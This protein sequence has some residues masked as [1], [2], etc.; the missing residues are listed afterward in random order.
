[1]NLTKKTPWNRREALARQIEMTCTSPTWRK[2][3]RD[4]ESRGRRLSLLLA[5]EE[6][7]GANQAKPTN[8]NLPNALAPSLIMDLRGRFVGRCCMTELEEVDK[9]RNVPRRPLV[10]SGKS[11]KK[12]EKYS[13][14]IFGRDDGKMKVEQPKRKPV[15]KGTFFSTH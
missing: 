6:S 1:M 3:R 12:T 4:K 15:V 10:P 8:L 11:P 14:E 7:T 9:W 13:T 5:N 2:G